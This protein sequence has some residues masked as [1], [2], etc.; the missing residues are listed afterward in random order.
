MTEQEY[1]TYQAER[2]QSVAQ[3]TDDHSAEEGEYPGWNE[4]ATE[5]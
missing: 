2:Q 1:I 5:L 3:Q 4:E